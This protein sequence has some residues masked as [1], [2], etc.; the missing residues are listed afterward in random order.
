MDDLLQQLDE[1]DPAEAP[2]LAD[3][4]ARVLSEALESGTPGTEPEPDDG[5]EASV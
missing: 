2:D 3:E 4:A 5:P 1:A